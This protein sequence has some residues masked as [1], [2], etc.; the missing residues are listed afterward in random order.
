MVFVLKTR[1]NR[2][3]VSGPRQEGRDPAALRERSDRP[4]RLRGRSEG[5]L[6]VPGDAQHGDPG[7]FRALRRVYAEWPQRE[8]RRRGGDR[9]SMG[10]VR[11]LAT[12]KHVGVNV[13]GRPDL[14]RLLHRGA[15]G[16]RDRHRGRSELHSSQ[17]EQTNRHYA[18]AAKIPMLEPSDSSEAKEFTRLAFELSEKYDTPVF[19]RTTTRISHAKGVVRLEEPPAPRS[20]RG[21]PR[22]GEMGDAPGEREAPSRRR[23]GAD[24]SVDRVRRD[25]GRNRIEWG[26]RSLGI[27]TSGSPTST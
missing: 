1:F 15:R 18:V 27:V 12:M 13:A 14:H 23:R 24:E 7:K 5:R 20:C 26:D 22:P 10:G 8:G 4:R 16:P 21:S 6:R 25:V 17:N 11:A 19:L 2:G 9:R 3:S